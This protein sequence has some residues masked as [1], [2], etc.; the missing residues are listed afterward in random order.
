VNIVHDDQPLVAGE[1]R[2]RRERLA[3]LPREL[4][5]RVLRLGPHQTQVDDRDIEMRRQLPR[6]E[7]GGDTQSQFPSNIARD[8]V[9]F[10]RA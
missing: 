1:Y 4:H 7:G 9:G 10:G 5:H 6:I 8:C 2:D 3:V